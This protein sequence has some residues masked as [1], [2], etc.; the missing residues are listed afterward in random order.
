M[1]KDI[2]VVVEQRNGTIQKVG[3][4]LIG[5]AMKLAADL[6]QQV[7]AVLIG[8]QIADK[9]SMLFHYGADKVVLI[10]DAMLEEYVTEPYAKALTAVVPG[11]VLF[12]A[13]VIGRDL[14]PRVAS[15]VHTGLTAGCCT[16]LAIDPESKLL[17]MTRL[18][19]DGSLMVTV[20]YRKCCPC[21][22]KLQQA[23]GLPE[24]LVP[25]SAIPFGHSERINRPADRFEPV[26]I[27]YEA[28]SR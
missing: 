20:V 5:E 8:N 9:A 25:F 21:M 26:R 15:R 27:N 2:Y 11:I 19:F 16:S 17:H 3:L 1:S 12:G 10:E 14:A 7:V 13:T 4:E 28:Y 23:F 24:S 22:K 18:A 6:Q